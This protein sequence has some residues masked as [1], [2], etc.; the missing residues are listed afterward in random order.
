V[1]LLCLILLGCASAPPPAPEE[2]PEPPRTKITFTGDPVK[3]LALVRTN[4]KEGGCAIVERSSGTLVKCPDA[5]VWFVSDPN[6]MEIT[7]TGFSCGKRV[8]ALMK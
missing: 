3:A 6:G 8:R 4:A 2:E 7:C 1:R 5:D